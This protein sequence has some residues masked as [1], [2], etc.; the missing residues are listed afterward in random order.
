MTNGYANKSLKDIFSQY[1]DDFAHACTESRNRVIRGMKPGD[2]L[3]KDGVIYGDEAR[4]AFMDRCEELKGKAMAILQPE[5]N[6]VK[7]AMTDSPPT[8]AVNT[9]TLLRLRSNVASEEIF[10]LMDRYGENYQAYKALAAIAADNGVKGIPSHPIEG[11]AQSI[12]ALAGTFDREI[13]LQRAESGHATRGFASI[14]E[15]SIDTTFPAESE[16]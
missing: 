11:R 13:N 4:A 10:D 3:P 2:M 1:I 9:A 14:V 5:L 16:N 7:K 15:M 6:A 12:E 8:E